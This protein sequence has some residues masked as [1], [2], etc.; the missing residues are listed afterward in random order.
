[1]QL[2]AVQLFVF[3]LSLSLS[4][5]QCTRGPFWLFSLPEDLTNIYDGLSGEYLDI[6][7]ISTQPHK[8]S[9]AI[10]VHF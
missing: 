5:E 4:R 2:F 6:Q 8:H 1:M 7:T 3:V 9:L 10:L